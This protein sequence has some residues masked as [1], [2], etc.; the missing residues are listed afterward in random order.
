MIANESYS[1]FAKA[2]QEQM[3]DEWG[4]DFKDRIVN[5]RERQKATLK[6]GWMLDEDFKALL[7]RIKHRIRYRVH[8][9]TETLI[10]KVVE[11]LKQLPPLAKPDFQVLKGELVTNEAGV[12]SELRATVRGER[13]PPD[14]RRA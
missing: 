4:I 1:D 3:K 6:Q 2:L 10:T 12:V 14:I 13:Q 11:S 7:E 8:Y 9:D 5:K